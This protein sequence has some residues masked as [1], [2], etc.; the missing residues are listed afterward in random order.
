MTTIVD[1][2]RFDAVRCEMQFSKGVSTNIEEAA[3]EIE[4]LTAENET[5]REGA[6]DAI[7]LLSDTDLH[8]EDRARNAMMRLGQLLNQQ[9]ATSCAECDCDDPPN[10]CNWIKARE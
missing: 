1:R 7:A 2:L 6:N 10:G 9:Q 3:A 4:R 5:L 8:S